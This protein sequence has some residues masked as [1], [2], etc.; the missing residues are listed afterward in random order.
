[1]PRVVPDPGL[2]GD[3][4]GQAREGPQLRA[5]PEG[6]GPLPEGCLHGPELVPRQLR[7]P[8]RAPGGSER[9]RSPALPVA[10]PAQDALAADSH[11]ASDLRV[12]E[13]PGREQPGRRE[14]A[15]LQCGEISSRTLCCSHAKDIAKDSTI[16]TIFYEIQ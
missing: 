7:F 8:P 15:L 12:R 2:P 10:V 3:D 9:F 13:V 1:M 16:V 5:E 6:Q 4:R 14:A 11:P